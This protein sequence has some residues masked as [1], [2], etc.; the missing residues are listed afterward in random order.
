MDQLLAVAVE[1][2]ASES[3][4]RGD[5]HGIAQR[6]A[7]AVGVDDPVRLR[8]LLLDVAD[9]ADGLVSVLEARDQLGDAIIGAGWI[10]DLAR[11]ANGLGKGRRMGSVGM[12]GCYPASARSCAWS[13]PRPRLRSSSSAIRSSVA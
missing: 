6:L 8:Q 12:R 3:Q 7:V 9:C 4:I 5:S 10:R 1:L 2:V 13:P 11:A